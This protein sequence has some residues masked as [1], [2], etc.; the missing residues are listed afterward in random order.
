M[1][2]QKVMKKEKTSTLIFLRI[3]LQG[4]GILALKVSVTTAR[5]TKAIQF[6]WRMGQEEKRIPFLSTSKEHGK[7]VGP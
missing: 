7:I 3:F 5:E 2:L 6:I 1:L 4:R